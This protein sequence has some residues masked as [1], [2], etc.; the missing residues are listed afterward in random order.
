MKMVSCT[1]CGASD[2]FERYGSRIC[3]Y[4]RSKY[5]TQVDDLIPVKSTIALDDDVTILLQK[6][7]TDPKNAR[8]YASLALDI[9]PENAEALRYLT[10]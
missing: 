2:Y 9:D 7:K 5:T 4:C 1:K 6:C 3:K 10:I 8:R